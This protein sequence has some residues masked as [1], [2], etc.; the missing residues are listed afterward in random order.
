M[1]GFAESFS[2]RSFGV[3]A[4]G[5]G[6]GFTKTAGVIQT[7]LVLHYDFGNTRSYTGSGTAV[8]DLVGNSDATLSNSPNYTSGY[9]SFNG[10]NQ[11]LMTNTSLTSKV[12]TDRTTISMWAYP[13]DNGVLLS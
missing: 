5:F 11:Y 2:D 13:S 8:A 3:A 12:T 7:G 10:T 9:L 4:Q 1:S 6:A